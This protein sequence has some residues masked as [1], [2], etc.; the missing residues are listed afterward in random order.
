MPYST[1]V[2]QKVLRSMSESLTTLLPTPRGML[3]GYIM[4]EYL[5][6][7]FSSTMDKDNDDAT[8]NLEIPWN[9]KKRATTSLEIK[10]KLAAKARGLK[11]K[12][13]EEEKSMPTVYDRRRKVHV[14]RKP[15]WGLVLT[16]KHFFFLN[17][18]TVLL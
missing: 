12:Y 4:G 5:Y 13:E 16:F 3:S 17:F 18:M 15:N 1:R 14:K 7:A 6:P 9:T 10:C 8:V 11:R 2:D